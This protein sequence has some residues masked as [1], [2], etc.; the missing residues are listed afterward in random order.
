MVHTYS[1]NKTNLVLDVNSGGVFVV[2]DLT[3]KLINLISAPLSEQPD[4]ALLSHFPENEHPMVRECYSEIYALYEGKQIFTED[5]CAGLTSK[6]GDAPVKAMC[7]HVAHDCNLRCRYCFAHTGDFGAGRGLMDFE[8]GKRAVDFLIEQSGSRRNLE[9]DFFGGEPLMNFSVVRQ[10]VDYARSREKETGK[11]FRFTTT[12]NGLLLDDDNIEY[13]N[14]E[15]SNVVLSL[16]GRKAVNDR[17]RPTPN[18]HGSY[19]VVLPK[20]KKLV[21]GRGN[22]DWYVRATFTKENIDFAE[23]VRHL[24]ELGFENISVE[25]VVLED[26]SP[27]ALTEAELPLIL[28]EYERLALMIADMRSNGKKINFFHFRLD[29][30]GGPC[31]LKRLRGCGCGNEYVAITPEGEIYPCHQFVGQPSWQMGTLTGGF[32]KRYPDGSTP[33]YDTSIYAKKDCQACFARFYCSG[34]CNAA[35]AAYCGG[36]LN[37]HPMSCE[38]ERKR[39][40]LAVWLSSI[41][42]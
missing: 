18:G 30:T 35:N 40:E 15:M 20:F 32:S 41:D 25:P 7:L 26:N 24:Y 27:Y 11:C 34:G 22:K 19:D 37:P 13:I 33:F 6:L 29:L 9:I 39:V 2:D 12:T 5:E 23:D 4:A 21:E 14:R 42:S 3:V 10:L 38:L 28:A 16:D 17:M 31:A 36:I 1:F 8:T